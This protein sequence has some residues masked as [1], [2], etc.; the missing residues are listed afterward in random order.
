MHSYSNKISTTPMISSIIKAELFPACY[1]CSNNLNIP[2]S[3]LGSDDK[4]IVFEKP[5]AMIAGYISVFLKIRSRVDLLPGHLTSKCIS[6]GKWYIT[7][8]PLNY[9]D[10]QY[11]FF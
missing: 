6:L 5:E 4:N 9:Q 11:S 3:S 1:S 8:Y 2:H 7:F 10:Q